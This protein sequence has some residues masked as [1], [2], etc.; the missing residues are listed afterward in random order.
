MNKNL[1]PALCL[2]IGF[3]AS[4]CGKTQN[5]PQIVSQHFEMINSHNIDSIAADYAS[6]VKI[7]STAFD[8]VR[9]GP[10]QIKLIFNRYFNSSPDLKYTIN[11]VIYTDT[12]ATVE[13]T[14]TGSIP[15]DDYTSPVYMRGKKYTLR[16]CTILHFKDGKITS[17]ASYFDQ[18]SFLHQIGYFDQPADKRT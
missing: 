13:Y 9:T 7:S 18:N 11:H 8:D 5:I 10:T 4:G 6:D 3:L 2:A 1:L 17:E 16:N 15:A 14:S 12:T